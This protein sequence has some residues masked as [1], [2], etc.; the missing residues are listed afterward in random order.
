MPV[1]AN[2]QPMTPA[3]S[4]THMRSLSSLRWMRFAVLSAS[5]KHCD[6]SV[7]VIDTL[8]DNVAS[9]SRSDATDRSVSFCC[10]LRESSWPTDRALLTY[11]GTLNPA[12][13]AARSISLFWLSD[14]R[15]LKT[16]ICPLFTYVFISVNRR[17]YKV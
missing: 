13:N 6:S 7:A 16:D 5:A 4:S 11:S 1:S 9:S 15:T 3:L 2:A 14:T 8:F 17:Y 10:D 12:A